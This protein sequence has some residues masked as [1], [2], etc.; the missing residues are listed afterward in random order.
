LAPLVVE[1]G[2]D[3]SVAPVRLLAPEVPSPFAPGRE[4][5]FARVCGSLLEGAGVRDGD[6]VALLRSGA[7]GRVAEHGDLAAVVG[8]DGR[9]ALWKVYP[10]GDGLRLG[11]GAG[12]PSGGAPPSRRAAPSARVAGVV[13]AVL[14]K[15]RDV[16]PA[17]PPDA[18]RTGE[19]GGAGATS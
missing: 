16:S 6:H 10:E 7:E 14:R 11:T 5:S 18:A 1:R 8:V 19:R 9:A 3:A 4:I 2:V 13:V 15:F 17:V 12:P